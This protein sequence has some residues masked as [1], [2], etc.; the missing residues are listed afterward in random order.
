[1]NAGD[2]T[3]VREWTLDCFVSFLRCVHAGRFDAADL[4]HGKALW[5]F[6]P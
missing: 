6:L 1:M 3:R 5:G 4:W 2:A